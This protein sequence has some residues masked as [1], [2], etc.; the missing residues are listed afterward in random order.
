MIDRKH[1]EALK[2]KFANHPQVLLHFEYNEE[3]S[4]QIYAALDLFVIPSL[5]EPCG[6]TQMIAMRYGTVPVGRA[7]GGLKDTILDCDD[8]AIPANKRNGFLFPHFT[9]ASEIG[10]L[11]R[12]FRLFKK[13]RAE[14]QA[15][16]KNGMRVDWS[17]E[18][19]SQEYLKLYRSLLKTNAMRRAPITA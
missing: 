10:T 7:T 5:Y 14:F 13:E 18:N 19:P 9:K 1:F 8:A 17:W 12:A 16:I 2:A 6:L 4:R 3:L 11:E 15:L